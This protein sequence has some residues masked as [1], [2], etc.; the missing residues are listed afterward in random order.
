M[1]M[2]KAAHDPLKESVDYP[3]FVSEFV[4]QKL[5]QYDLEATDE[6]ATYLAQDV[7][8][9]CLDN[10]KRVADLTETELF[11]IE[12]MIRDRVDGKDGV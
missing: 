8:A 4:K 3:D 10:N 1:E 5:A 11:H 2:G 6:V 12:R 7:E 9:Y